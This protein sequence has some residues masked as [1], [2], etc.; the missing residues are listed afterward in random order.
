[1]KHIFLMLILVLSILSI[2]ASTQ[3]P[4]AQQWEYKVAVG[5]CHDEKKLNAL[6]SE[7]WELATYATWGT[8]PAPIDTCVFKRAK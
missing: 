4:K 3:S 6:G 8:N 1:M 2:S 5:K 7:G